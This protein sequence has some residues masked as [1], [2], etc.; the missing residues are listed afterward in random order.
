MKCGDIMLANYPFTDLSGSKVRPVL[1]VSADHFNRGE[2]LVVLP[3]SSTTSDDDPYAFLVAASAP[4]FGETGLRQSSSIKWT[5]PMTVASRVIRR[6]M[7]CLGRSPLS[8]IQSRVQSLFGE[9]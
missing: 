4:S 3:I 1:I 2:D 7:G 8:E 9:P 5:K 6:R